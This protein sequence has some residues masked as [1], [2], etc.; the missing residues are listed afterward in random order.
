M[1][2]RV[3]KVRL[4]TY[5]HRFSG[6]AY[7]VTY[8]PKIGPDDVTDRFKLGQLSD[9]GVL[10]SA[11]PLVGSGWPLGLAVTLDV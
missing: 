11:A 8:G 10:V 9:P 2:A 5:H 3:S 4:V 1:A 6:V 7:L